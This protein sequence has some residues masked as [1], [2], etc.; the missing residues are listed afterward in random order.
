MMQGHRTYLDL[1][2]YMRQHA[3]QQPERAAYTVSHKGQHIKQH[4]PG[5]MAYAVLPTYRRR[6]IK[7]VNCEHS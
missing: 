3:K 1:S 4:R 7:E 2:L 6:S 5:H